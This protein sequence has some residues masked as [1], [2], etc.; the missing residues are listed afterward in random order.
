[1]KPRVLLAHGLLW[2]NVARL[3]NAFRRAGFAVE[4]VAPGRH[5]IHR[6]SS[7]DRTFRYLPSRP[8]ASLLKAIETSKPELVIPCDDLIVGHLHQL[9]KE[10]FRMGDRS[11][12][13]AT[14]ALIETSLGSPM[15]YDLLRSRRL[16]GRLSGLPDVHIPQTDSIES[17][18]QLRHWIDKHGLPAVLKL[19][20]SWG[21]MDVIAIRE[22]SAIARAFLKM[23]LHRSVMR[24]LKRALFGDI[25]PLFHR[26]TVEAGVSVQS[27]VAGRLANCAIACWRGEVIYSIAVE[28]VRS[29]G[30]FGMA[31]VVR[32]VEGRSMI[33]TARSITRNLQ[34]SGL[35]G[36]DFVLN[37]ATEEAHLI[38]INPRATQI[39]HL[40]CRAGATL[41]SALRLAGGFES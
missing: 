16:L 12:Q 13:F 22:E 34:L 35:Y 33:A 24:R 41:P 38:E 1:M 17:L 31:T 36:F 29:Q 3:S 6:M 11:G 27:F 20:G 32:V 21:G 4:A 14:A 15:S 37:D 18:Y 10:S 40:S 2:P 26:R 19:D 39:H 25:E 7:P 9:H 5:P 8:R 30:T 28:V 23:R